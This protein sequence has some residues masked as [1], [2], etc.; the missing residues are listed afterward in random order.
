MSIY[1]DS[2]KRGNIDLSQQKPN[3]NNN[4]ASSS[5][6][7]N[8]YLNE[9]KSESNNA[10]ETTIDMTTSRTTT[11]NDATLNEEVTGIYS[12]VKYLEEKL[13]HAHADK[14]FV[15]SLW[16][17]LQAENPDLTSAI[18]V[19]VQRE[20][21]K[22]EAK[23]Q[24]VLEIL[25]AKDEKLEKLQQICKENKSESGHLK[26]KLAEVESKMISKEDELNCLL[27]NIKTLQDKEQMY[28]Q[29][30]RMRDDKYANVLKESGQIND[31]LTARLQEA[32]Q[33]C[34][35]HRN[36]IEGLNVCHFS[37]YFC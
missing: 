17:Q 18:G 20:K 29:M 16:R 33:E 24:K 3:I 19:V 21:E 23:D 2:F 28:E 12:R 22:A 7:L 9:F 26:E 4:L 13:A 6:N 25:N 31:N 15:W 30:I 10:Y 5:F 11:T 34:E 35:Q 36:T 27:L 8:N 1:F 14:E 37:V 32:Y